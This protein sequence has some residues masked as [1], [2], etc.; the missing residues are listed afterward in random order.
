MKLKLPLTI[1]AAFL[2][3]LLSTLQAQRHPV[4]IKIAFE[5]DGSLSFNSVN[6]DY[7]D[8]YVNINF[9]EIN[10][11]MARGSIPYHGMIGVSPRK[12]LTIQRVADAVSPAYTWNYR[13]YRGSI[14]VDL[15]LDYLYALPVKPGDSIRITRSNSRELELVFNLKFAGDTV[16]ACR[17]GMVC[18]NDFE[19]YASRNGKFTVYHKDKSFSEYSG[20]DAALVYPGSYVNIGDPILVVKEDEKGGKSVK[21]KNYFLDRDKVRNPDTGYKYTSFLPLFH[22][23]NAGDVKPEEKITYVAALTEN[24]MLQKLSKKEL[25]KLEKKRK[26]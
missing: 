22:T 6:H 2:L 13:F 4:E 3:V 18:N 12:L 7:C 14:Y 15:N 23:A 5:Q 10:G 26:K 1:L 9:P 19:C 8:Y 11:Y 16:Y 25:K 17:S 21:F 20:F 24:M